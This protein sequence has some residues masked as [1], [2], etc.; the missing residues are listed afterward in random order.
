MTRT[1]AAC[2]AAALAIAVACQG[3]APAQAPRPSAAEPAQGF[4]GSEAIIEI[5]G[6]A[7]HVRA[8][9]RAG[10]GGSSVDASYR[11]WLDDVEL[12]DVVWLDTG[13]LRARVPAGLPL[14]PLDLT[15][16]GP[17]GRGSVAAA[18][19]VFPGASPS[20]TASASL[21]A[22]A[23]VGQ[24]VTLA[25]TVQNGGDTPVDGV[26]LELTPGIPGAIALLEPVEPQDVPAAERRTLTA[27]LRAAAEGAV[28]LSIAAVG[29]DPRTGAAV[30]AR[31]D[32]SVRVE[33]PSALSA[34]LALPP[35]PV[36]PQSVL[37]VTMTVTN[38]GAA[39]AVD[40]MP[41]PLEESAES[42]A[43]AAVLSAPSQPVVL[44][45]G[46]SAVFT[47]T[48]RAVAAGSLVLSAAATGVDVNDGGP[49]TAT[50]SSGPALV[51]HS[52][53]TVTANPFGDDS[54]FAFVAP[55]GGQVYVGPNR[56]GTG[57][58]RVQ[59]DG[60]GPESLALSFARDATGNTMG[61][62]ASPYASIGFTGC[63]TDSLTDACGP[64]DEDGRGLLTS[65]SFA[66]EE[67]LVMGGARSGGDLDYVYLSRAASSP[68]DFSYVDLSAVLGGNT[69]GF[70]AAHATGDRL[71]LGFPDN[72]GSR[73]YGIVLLKPPPDSGGVDAVAG[74][75]A[76]DLNLH[77]AYA[78][79][80]AT[81]A[82][83]SMVDAIAE[84]GGRLY[85]FDDAGCLV[86]TSSTPSGKA[87][88]RPCSPSPGAAYDRKGSVEPTR[89]HDLEPHERAWPQVVAWK[90][91]LYAIRN[92]YT[93]PQ[94]WTCDPAAGADA[95]VCEATDWTL[96]AADP[97]TLRTRLGYAGV[98]A[99]SML[100]AT[101]THLYLGLDD[102][103]GGIHVFRTRAALP[104]ASD[105]TGHDGCP[106]GTAGC[107]GLGGDGMGAPGVLTR[108]FD[109][110][111]VAGADG[112]VDLF[113]TAG[114]GTAAVRLIRMDP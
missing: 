60:T 85:F 10:A 71:Y 64:D 7:F 81:F 98:T 24:E 105:F 11:A 75:D 69:R 36:A 4:A 32:A 109:A 95:A 70:S 94:L 21:P 30:E 33:R 40:V 113:L 57:L 114:D 22:A 76:L 56:S 13:R 17:Y 110:K 82:S 41:G 5:V 80:N 91:R 93:G 112:R 37:V 106:A 34:T 39:T 38:T 52:A 15:V 46:A 14:G 25:L 6:S 108:I 9:Q 26:R 77:D 48:C 97:T 107:Q 61:N 103:L 66:G 67:W 78:A 62:T 90:G 23:N 68:L 20:L 88:F 87:D 27:R 28:S 72:G 19:E 89:Q 111:V 86:S 35:G 12:L 101:P 31:A 104:V 92:T 2:L 49:R 84:L 99:A 42:T 54:P 51:P 8:V 73:P 83:V 50:A 63:Q 65:V 55:H 100:L 16:E 102:P 59:R 43:A 18:Y 44:A 29:T 1:D 53:P 47:W 45:G 96:L 58:V 79:W 3:P 74:I